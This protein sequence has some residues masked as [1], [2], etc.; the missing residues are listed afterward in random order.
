MKI[1]DLVKTLEILARN[2]NKRVFILKELALFLN[3]TRP[4]AAMALIRGRK[5]GLVWRTRNLWI[6]RLNPPNLE[7]IAFGL[8]SPSYISFESALYQRGIL[9]QSPRGALALATTQR[10]QRVETPLGVVRL[11]HLKP[12]LFFGF[13][14]DRV[15]YPEKAY[16]DL[17]Y[18]RSRRGENE[19]PETL[20]LK[21][22][23]RK[24]LATFGKAYPPRIKHRLTQILH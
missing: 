6:N 10:S 23:D 8:S 18:A 20:Y 12:S 1:L 21:Y 15:A 22:L 13:D 17:V 19:Y 2:H 16:L 7:E 14:K 4:A 11:I 5:H 24:R 9:S 3:V